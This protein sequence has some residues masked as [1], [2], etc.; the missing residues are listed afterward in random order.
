MIQIICKIFGIVF[1]AL[2]VTAR[3]IQCVVN[4]MKKNE[5]LNPHI[6]PSLMTKISGFFGGLSGYFTSGRKAMGHIPQDKD[7]KT[8]EDIYNMMG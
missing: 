7:V 6:K 1:E 8:A 5:N 4:P 2:F 3:S